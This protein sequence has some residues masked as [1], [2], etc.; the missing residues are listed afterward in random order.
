[1][2]VVR[3]FAGGN[4]QEWTRYL[5]AALQSERDQLNAVLNTIEQGIAI[6]G[7]DRKIQFMNPSLIKAFGNGKG[8]VCFKH[9]YHL[10]EPCPNCRL[11]KVI[12]GSTE[13]WE[14]SFPNGNTFDITY[15]PFT[16]ADGA[17]CVLAAFSDVTKR[18]AAELELVRLND[19]KTELLAQKT[20]QLDRISREV[21]KLEQE[22]QRF[23]SFLAVVAH[24]LKSPLGVSQAA[25]SGILGGYLGQL[26]E[27][28]R[29]MLERINRRLEGLSALV[30]DLIDIPLI[31]TGHLVHEM[32][33]MSLADAVMTS[34]NEYRPSAAEKGLWLEAVV[35][36]G[37]PMIYG[38]ARRISQV[39]NNLLS[40]AIKYSEHGGILVRASEEDDLVRI[41]VSDTGIGILPQDQP[42]LF[43]DFF[44]GKNV[45]TVKGTGLGLSICRRII[46]A[47]GG[48]IW[49]ESPNPET[50]TGSRFVF[51]LPKLAGPQVCTAGGRAPEEYN[52]F[53]EG[54]KTDGK[55]AEDPA[56]RR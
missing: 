36:D 28:Q 6:I 5:E 20:E 31:E 19:L 33:E 27:Q 32:K 44:R 10:N 18:K 14:W 25:I 4:E 56:Y 54:G 26:N 13:K 40:N 22:K 47:H 2:A 29:D 37:L 55:K 50:N 30:D 1:M 34:V 11:S 53:S 35:P 45:G 24:D 8:E 16:D 21:G 43:E 12:H 39:L 46:E 42:R 9:L 17:Q 38:S 49:A 51:T 41:S 7:Q 48:K 15:S 52:L 3:A 23:V